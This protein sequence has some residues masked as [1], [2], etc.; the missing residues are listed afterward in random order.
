MAVRSTHVAAGRVTTAASAAL[1]YTVPAD[2]TLIVHGA[3]LH[4][5]GST[6]GLLRLILRTGA[7]DVDGVR[8]TVAGG[9]VIRVTGLQWVL[10][11]GD[12]IRVQSA[13]TGLDVGFWISG[14]LL[15]GNP[16]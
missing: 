7:V 11:A 1:L 2:R 3:V 4:L 13:P 8:D 6:Q 15:A 12:S 16:T 5:A 14:S 10:L 9:T